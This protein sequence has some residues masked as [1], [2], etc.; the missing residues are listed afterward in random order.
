MAELGL[1]SILR[2]CDAYRP[3][4]CDVLISLDVDVPAVSLGLWY[5]GRFEAARDGVL[6]PGRAGLE[7][8][9]DV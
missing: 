1:S 7:T 5:R 4:K 6:G 8:F 2:C 3:K 9:R